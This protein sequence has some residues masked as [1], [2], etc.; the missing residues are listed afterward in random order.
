MVLIFALNLKHSL[1]SVKIEQPL[2]FLLPICPCSFRPLWVNQSDLL[3]SS[4]ATDRQREATASIRHSKLGSKHVGRKD[5]P[6][7][8]SINQPKQIQCRRA[9]HVRTSL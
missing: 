8:I 6:S 2:P 9:F 3:L 5:W 7:S 4:V 1:S